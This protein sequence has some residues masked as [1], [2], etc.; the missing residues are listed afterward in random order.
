MKLCTM[1]LRGADKGNYALKSNR[2]IIKSDRIGVCGIVNCN[3]SASDSAHPVLYQRGAHNT[4]AVQEDVV[5]GL[6]CNHA[7]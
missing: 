6:R 1:R 7:K 4:G 5:F 2:Q 3:E